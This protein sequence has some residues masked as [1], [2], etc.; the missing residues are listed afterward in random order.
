[1]NS[2]DLLIST[3]RL[4]GRQYNWTQQAYARD[5][6]YQPVD[7]FDRNAV[8]FSIIGAICYVQRD[9]DENTVRAQARSYIDLAI[10]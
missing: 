10:I 3:G 4:I 7:I 2:V 1:M 5:A 8:L 6:Q 9:R